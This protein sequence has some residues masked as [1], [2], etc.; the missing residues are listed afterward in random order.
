M[1]KIAPDTYITVEKYKHAWDDSDMTGPAIEKFARFFPSIKEWNIARTHFYDKQWQH[2]MG[3]DTSKIRENLIED[4]VKRVTAYRKLMEKGDTAKAARELG[5]VLHYLEDTWTPSH[6][7]RGSDGKIKHMYDYTKQSPK[8]HGEQDTP[9]LDSSTL[10]NATN[11][12][13]E[14]LGIIQQHGGDPKMLEKQLDEKV[15]P[16]NFDRNYTNPYAPRVSEP[17]WKGA[18]DAVK[19][20][21]NGYL[22]ERFRF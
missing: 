11:A 8:L 14:L 3:E 22:L 6:V 19:N 5:I 7:A 20:K 10:R 16:I 18:V 12:G 1:K 13:V 21:V 4:T 9:D 15:Y 17:P 2:G